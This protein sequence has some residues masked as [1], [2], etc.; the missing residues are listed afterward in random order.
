MF[1]SQSPLSP[2]GRQNGMT[3]I[4]LILVMGV[5]ATV[6]ALVGPSLSDFFKGR[7]SQEEIRRL[8]ALTRFARAEAISRSAPLEVWMDPKEQ[9][10]GMRPRLEADDDNRPAPQYHMADGLYFDIDPGVLNSQGQAI[11]AFLPDG[12]LDET[13]AVTIAIRESATREMV[14]E[15]AAV[16]VGYSIR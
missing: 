6:M 12:T 13:S 4:E 2:R 16:G 5:L 11:I 9:M 3:L 10:Y 8:L 15:R 7:R 1:E 14:L